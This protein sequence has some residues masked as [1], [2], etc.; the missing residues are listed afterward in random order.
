MKLRLVC[1]F[2]ILQ[3]NSFSQSNVP[4]W[5]WIKSIG[6]SGN[7]SVV[8]IRFKNNFLY[9]AGN[10]SSPTIEW[11]HTTLTNSGGSDIF[12]AKLDT[13]GNTIWVKSFGGAGNDNVQ[14][15]EVN[16]NGVVVLL[17]KSLSEVLTI[18]AIH[19]DTAKHFYATF[20]ENGNVQ[21]A[22]RLL[23]HLNY[24][25]VEID[26]DG[27]VYLAGKYQQAFTFGDSVVT[28]NPPATYPDGVPRIEI[29]PGNFIYYYL[30]TPADYTKGSVLL[31]YNIAGNPDWLKL[32]HSY[33]TPE[34]SYLGLGIEYDNVNHNLV[35]ML[36]YQYS[37]DFNNTF[38][39][40]SSSPFP[41]YGIY[42]TLITQ[43]SKTGNIISVGNSSGSALNFEMN[44][45]GLGHTLRVSGRGVGSTS[46]TSLY[47]LKNGIE[48]RHRTE[49]SGP[50]EDQSNNIFNFPLYLR[51]DDLGNVLSDFKV[52][53]TNF[54][55]VDSFAI[56]GSHDLFLSKREIAGKN[57][58]YIGDSFINDTLFIKKHTA[59]TDT[60]FVLY[61][62]GGSDIFLG[63]YKRRGY[64][65]LEFKPFKDTIKVCDGSIS[66]T[67]DSAYLLKYYGAKN[68]SYHWEP[69]ASFTAPDKLQT[70]VKIVLDTLVSTLTVTDAEGN[71]ISKRIVF[72]GRHKSDLYL[73]TSYDT[74]ICD[75]NF[76]TFT[77]HGTTFSQCY[78][79]N[80]P[81]TENNNGYGLVSNY[82]DSLN[83]EQTIYINYPKYYLAYTPSNYCT[84]ADTTPIII[85]RKSSKNVY[86]YAEICSGSNYTIPGDTTYINVTEGFRRVR[87]LQTLQGCDSTVTTDVGII[88]AH[89]S[90]ENVN[91]CPGN[92]YT[93]SDGTKVYNVQQN[94]SH[95][96]MYY[97]VGGCDSL[98]FTTYLNVLPAYNQTEHISVCAGSSY[99]FPDNT[100][101]INI[102]SDTFHVSHLGRNGINCDSI[103]NT[104]ITV[105]PLYGKTEN[106]S[107]CP[108]ANYTFP[109]NSIVN[110][111][112][113]AIDRY[114]HLYAQTGC[115]S[116]I[117][118][119]ITINTDY[120][121]TENK[122]VCSG[123]NYTFPDGSVANNIVSDV[124]HISHLSTVAGCDSVITTNIT[125]VSGYTQTE[126]KTVCSGSNYTFPD[127]SVANNI[128]STITH[129]SHLSTVAGCDSVI[130]TNIS[131]VAVDTALVKEGLLLSAADITALQYQWLDC[132]TGDPIPLATHPTYTV[133]TAGAYALDITKVGNCRDTSSCY[134]FTAAD[135]ESAT[136][137]LTNMY[138]QPA[139]NTL[140][141]VVQTTAATNLNLSLSD[142]SGGVVDTEKYS[143]I[144]GTNTITLDISNLTSGIY[145]LKLFKEDTQQTVIQKVIKN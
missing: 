139:N 100:V 90:W 11:D 142:I 113:S 82:F 47:I 85:N 118:T 22:N 71:S 137:F 15:L 52:M 107:L 39:I 138:P 97:G 140:T 29:S 62:Q 98:V 64:M 63:R 55:V 5:E 119:Y 78:L 127:G 20:N 28:L 3:L 131:V 68:L 116:F 42:K 110:N 102:F 24:T 87:K 1:L 135:F 37:L 75:N 35:A 111:I 34:E 61:N 72:Y 19:L 23:S 6:G 88:F 26:E 56:P 144:V 132:N 136:S 117:H 124:N 48:V 126:N 38:Y 43:I 106:I 76:A 51:S 60:A 143:L 86:T 46:S 12:I 65:P 91:I 8:D 115:D 95:D 120:T 9:V 70:D 79:S 125:V 32:F 2:I 74:S 14:Q 81:V 133:T 41:V 10:F 83:Q 59:S 104:F 89:H 17:G 80:S 129:I 73:T 94:T 123:S 18:G 114:S 92:N 128:T 134:I 84:V 108:G 130:T 145:L 7:D 27:N 21:T 96:K 31:K 103:I 33:L 45:K 53:D 112:T 77:L 44:N 67:M 50:Y 93:F 99:V 101:F 49:Y 121:Q 16:N 36:D 54:L 122:T 25:D 69:A 105:N 4:H 66:V 57:A 141:I 40:Y 13:N 109:D 58:L 30:T